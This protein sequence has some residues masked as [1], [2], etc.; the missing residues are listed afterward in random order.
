MQ[1]I[2]FVVMS[3]NFLQIEPGEKGSRRWQY[4]IGG[5]SLFVGILIGVLVSYG[6]PRLSLSDGAAIGSF[7]KKTF[8]F[9]KD[10][11]RAVRAGGDVVVEP[12]RLPAPEKIGETALPEK[13]SAQGMTV[14]DVRTGTVLYDKNAYE[15]RPIASIT[16]LMSALVLLEKNPDWTKT[17]Q[18]VSDEVIDTHMYAGDTYT[19]EELWRAALIGSS[20]KAILTLAHALDWPV[21]AFIARM[22]QKAIELG[23]RHTQFTDPS[24]LDETNISTPADAAILLN[25]ALSNQKIQ[26][27]LLL[28]EHNLY[29]NER[30]KAH[31][32]W[33]TNW[34]LLGWIPHT[35]GNVEGGKTGYL[36]VAGYNFTIRLADTAGHMIDVVVFG[37]KTHEARFT[38]ARDVA[39]SVLQAYRWGE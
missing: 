4:M 5:A 30:G 9:A 25:E 22:N 17:A 31:H 37:A 10:R 35:F 11:D 27:T 32:M 6:I 23:M 28:H 8:P 24:G 34:L 38:E 18:V 2:A 29:S 36:P 33:N 3:N 15:P 16:K 39:V 20:N 12:V 21:D 19:L 13:F 1:S 14:K 26:G 7:A